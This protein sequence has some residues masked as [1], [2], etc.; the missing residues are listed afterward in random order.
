MEFVGIDLGASSTRYVSH[1]GKIGVLPNNMVFLDQNTRVDLE[2]YSSEIEGALDVTIETDKESKYFPVRVLVGDLAMRY[3]PT[4]QRPS[5]ISNKHTQ[6]INYVSAILA[7]AVCKHK[8]GMG[9]NFD[10]YLALP[11][12]EVNSAKD[13]VK[14]QL[15]GTYKVTFNKLGI[16]Y[17]FTV[18]NVACYEE[19]FLALLA[20]F[21]DMNGKPKPAAQKYGYG[22]V[23]GLDIGASTTDLAV[24]SNMRYIEKSGQTFKTGGNIA[25]DFLADDLRAMYGFDVPVEIAEMAIAEG[26]IQLGNTYEDISKYVES[27]KKKFAEQVVEQIQGYFRKIN[28]PIQSI[29]AIV[30]SGGGSMRSEYVDENMNIVITSQPM[31]HYIT[32]ELHKVCPGIEVEPYSENPRYANISGLFIRASI[33]VARRKAAM[34]NASNAG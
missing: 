5:G 20:Y 12:V 13:Y 6:Q 25:R 24:A 15:C 30:V 33:D 31:S 29:R 21:F 3:S 28:I 18:Q 34:T 9:D 27:A 32:E 19:S 2:P 10:I 16:T 8:N 11:P 4:N 23:L 17:E 26:R 1:K 14:E 22:N 7:A